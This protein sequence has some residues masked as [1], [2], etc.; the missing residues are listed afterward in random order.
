MTGNHHQELDLTIGSLVRPR[1]VLK[2]ISLW[3]GRRMKN[4]NRVVFR[5]VVMGHLTGSGVVVDVVG[6]KAYVMTPPAFG[7][8]YSRNL[9]EVER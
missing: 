7:W 1:G 9:C 2:S 4:E 8:T 6:D 3:D 5:N